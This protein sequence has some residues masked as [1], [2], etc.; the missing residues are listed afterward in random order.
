MDDA[1]QAKK[2]AKMFVLMKA[3]MSV[4]GSISR[5]EFSAGRYLDPRRL[6][7]SGG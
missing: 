5:E 4:C 7:V 2:A 3:T 1:K 6:S